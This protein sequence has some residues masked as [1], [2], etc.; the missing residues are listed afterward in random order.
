MLPTRLGDI[1]KGRPADSPEGGLENP[2]KTGYRVGGGYME[3]GRPE[4]K[5]IY[6]GIIVCIV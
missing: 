5:K 2:D 6:I 3:F 1:H 4:M